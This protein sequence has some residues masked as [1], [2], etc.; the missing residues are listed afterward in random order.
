MGFVD[1]EDDI[2]ASK[3]VHARSACL[4][5]EVLHKSIVHL[6]KKAHPESS[7]VEVASK[8][9]T[10]TRIGNEASLQSMSMCVCVQ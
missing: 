10:S 6:A 3:A 9:A 2:P 1:V 4:F 5:A 7:R 8:V